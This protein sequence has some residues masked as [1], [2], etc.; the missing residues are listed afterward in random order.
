MSGR[1]AFDRN[2]VRFAECL[3]VEHGC[4]REE[5]LQGSLVFPAA[6]SQIRE[7]VKVETEC[8]HAIIPVFPRIQYVRVPDRVDL[9]ERD[10]P[11]PR[12]GR[13]QEEVPVYRLGLVEA[14]EPPRYAACAPRAVVE[15]SEPDRTEVDVRDPLSDIFDRRVFDCLDVW[16][17]EI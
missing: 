13:E 11:P 3:L 8:R 14:V 16:V 12:S 10:D 17:S 1:A 15:Q 7:V 6:Q 4:L 9:P 5:T 2:G